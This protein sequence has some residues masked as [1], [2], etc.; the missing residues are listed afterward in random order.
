MARYSRQRARLE[1]NPRSIG[2]RSGLPAFSWCVFSDL[3]GRPGMRAPYR[4]R[5]L[6]VLLVCQYGNITLRRDLSYQPSN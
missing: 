2:I 6:L 3:R 1:Q 5:P 4:H